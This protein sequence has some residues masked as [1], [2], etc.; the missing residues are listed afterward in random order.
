MCE[1]WGVTKK[2]VSVTR[3]QHM[4]LFTY[5]NKQRN[6]P[7][8]KFAV[9]QQQKLKTFTLRIFSSQVVLGVET[10]C[11]FHELIFIFFFYF[12]RKPKLNPT[13][14][15]KKR[16]NMGCSSRYTVASLLL[17]LTVLRVSHFFL[18]KTLFLHALFKIN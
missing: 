8:L 10:T 17:I 7:L 14:L 15:F 16:G 6:S 18:L 12:C 2:K 13:V 9:P 5:H 11:F 3:H 4:G 1:Y